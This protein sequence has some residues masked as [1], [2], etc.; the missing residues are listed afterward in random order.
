MR[1]IG[2]PCWLTLWRREDGKDHGWEERIVIW[3][4][5]EEE[6]SWEEEMKC[7]GERNRAERY[8]EGWVRGEGEEGVMGRRW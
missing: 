4:G 5:V 7:F 6:R 3:D 2:L 8:S 1:Y